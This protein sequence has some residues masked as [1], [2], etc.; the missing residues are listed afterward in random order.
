MRKILI[1]TAAAAVLGGAALAAMGGMGWLD[2]TGLRGEERLVRTRVEGYWQARMDGDLEAIAGYVHPLQ[3]QV[4]EP[5]IL[6]T[7]GYELHGVAVDGDE[8]T[9]KVTVKSRL[10]HPVLSSRGRTLEMDS[11]WVK[12]EGKWYMAITPTNIYDTIRAHQGTWTPPTTAPSAP[13][14]ATTTVQ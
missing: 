9:A 11:R 14:D 1:G 3:G 7:E 5:G 4:P 10:K 13:V 8:A 12:Y 2:A 6:M